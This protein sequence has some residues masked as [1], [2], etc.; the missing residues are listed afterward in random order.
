ML[1][2]SLVI[3][4]CD[5]DNDVPNEEELITTLTYTLTPEAGGNPVVFS[6][7]DIDGDGGQDPVITQ[8]SLASNTIYDGVIELLNESETPAVDITEEVEAE[9]VDHQFFY[10]AAGANAIFLYTD[11]DADTKPIGITTQVIIGDPSSGAMT[12]ILRH[13][14]DKSAAGVDQGAII[15]AGGETD[16]EVTFLLTIN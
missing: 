9:A 1:L 2:V 12:V 11:M 14:P 5:K 15:N 13:R 10:S 8:G 7:R 4:S 6:F 16:I 3:V